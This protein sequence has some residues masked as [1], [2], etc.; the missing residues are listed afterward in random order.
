MRVFPHEPALVVAAIDTTALGDFMRWEDAPNGGPFPHI[1]ASLP[2]ILQ[3]RSE[4]SPYP[5]R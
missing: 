3:Q 2:L 1:Y 4:T 5:R